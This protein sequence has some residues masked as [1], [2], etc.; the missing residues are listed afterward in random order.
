MNNKFASIMCGVILSASVMAPAFAADGGGEMPIPDLMRGI[1]MTP[2]KI[3]AF[4]VC[5]VVGT[6]IAI[7]RMTATDTKKCVNDFGWKSDN[8]MLKAVSPIVGIPAGVY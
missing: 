5:T 1:T 6:P 3:A 2:M 8:K 7:L 4:G